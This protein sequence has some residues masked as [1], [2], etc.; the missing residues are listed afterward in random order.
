MQSQLK[1]LAP[2][3]T[4]DVT[5]PNSSKKVPMVMV[6]VPDSKTLM[7]IPL[8][9]LSQMTTTTAPAT[10]S[11]RVTAT[12]DEQQ[13]KDL[14]NWSD[15]IGTLVG[16][17]LRFKIN[18][19]GCLELLDSED[20]S[21]AEYY[22]D[23]Q[24]QRQHHPPPHIPYQQQPYHCQDTNNHQQ[25]DQKV[26]NS[27]NNTG[28]SNSNNAISN[29][30]KKANKIK[31]ISPGSS[32]LRDGP[33]NRRARASSSSNMTTPQAATTP[34]QSS[35]R[36]C[37]TTMPIS[38]KSETNQ[39]TFLLEKL[40]PKKRIDEIK[41]K[42]ENWSI[43]DVKNFVDDIPGCA[44]NGQLFESQ[45]ICGKSL[46]HLDQKDLIDIIQIRLG[47]AIKIYNAIALIKP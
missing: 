16:C 40:I 23:N 25:I 32:L 29:N 11:S 47:P 17:D 33:D 5:L 12:K 30:C 39:Q 36:N 27:N 26:N 44:G 24:Q 4:R 13:A 9:T 15:G 3:M 37:S 43:E 7:A 20:E 45:Q 1:V 18:Q 10:G 19:L 38:K 34:T 31:Q 21:N 28:S 8:S 22:K 42:V 6:P 35:I 2:V 41:V 14:L 46:M